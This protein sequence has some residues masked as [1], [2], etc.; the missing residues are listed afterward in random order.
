MGTALVP[1]VRSAKG[2]AMSPVAAWAT[3]LVAT[4]AATWALDA[5]AAAT[6]AALV[7]SG[8]LTGLGH[9]WVVVVLLVSYTVWVLGLR[10]NLG[11]NG[12][13]LAAT[14]TSTNVLSKLAYDLTRRRFGEGS[15]ARL[16]AA[17][18]YT[19][20]E[21]AKEV[22]YYVA[23]F[24]AAAATDAITTDE[25]LIFLAG[26]NLG[27]AFYEAAL[28]RLTRTVVGRDRGH[29]SFDTD[30]VPAEYLTDYYRSVEPDEIATIA[31]LVDAMR[32]A[33]RDQPILYFGTGPTLHHVFACAETASE[34][35]LG[36]YLPENLAE[37]QRWIERAPDAHDWRPFVRYTLQCEGNPRPTEDEVT[38]REDLT[39]AKI[40]DL[41]RVDAH[42]PRPVQRNYPMVVSAYCADSATADRAT[43]QVFMRH[44]TGLVEP[45]GLFLTAALRRCRGY[46][47]GGK[48]FPGADIDEHDLRATLRPEFAPR[49]QKIEVI[50]T[51]QHDA[52]GYGAIVLCRARRTRPTP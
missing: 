25:A 43:W 30:W 15:A 32:H 4:V 11:A 3:S 38:A 47:V 17:V 46:T 6:G 37:I 48:T 27:A 26:A 21:V 20:T 35:H 28:A 31:F 5:W 36:D 50:P 14:G 29:A 8:L 10:A 2:S 51:A 18:A 12:S 41:V 1:P 39:R 23:A 45:G 19:A 52:H 22:P 34:I 42:H 24:G 44:I 33:E 16:A 49:H 9:R 40:T 13:L 7:A